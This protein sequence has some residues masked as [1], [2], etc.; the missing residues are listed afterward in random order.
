MKITNKTYLTLSQIA[1]LGPVGHIPVAP[2]TFGTIAAFLILF[3]LGPTFPALLVMTVVTFV[4]GIFSSR[5]AESIFATEDPKQV[6]ID[7]VAGF[8]FAMLFFDPNV[9]NLVVVFLL[10]RLFDIVKPPPIKYIEKKFKGGAGIML[11][12]MI[13]GLYTAV[14]LIICN[15]LLNRS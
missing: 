9:I 6:I 3:L 7:E 12:D 4:I 14:L 1:T 5:A 15:A 8:F 2:G 11:D 13:A 10:F